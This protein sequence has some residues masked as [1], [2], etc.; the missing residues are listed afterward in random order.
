M[1]AALAFFCACEGVRGARWAVGGMRGRKGAREAENGV[2]EVGRAA[3][4]G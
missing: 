1:V 2:F 3:K 4:M